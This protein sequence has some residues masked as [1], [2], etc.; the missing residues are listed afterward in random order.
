MNRKKAQN[1]LKIIAQKNNVSYNHVVEEIQKG[2]DI[3]MN[4]PDPHI[5]AHWKSISH[6]GER[7]TP[8]EVICYI[9]DEI[10]NNKSRKQNE[11]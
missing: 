8:Y 4:N 2:I 7:P 3:G 5:R 10:H 11:N 9:T 1:A 6:N